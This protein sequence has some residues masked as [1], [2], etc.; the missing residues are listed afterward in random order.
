MNIMPPHNFAPRLIAW[1]RQHGRHNLPWQTTNPYHIWLSEIMLQ[2]TQVA[3]VKPYFTRFIQTLPTLEALAHAS[4]DQVLSLWSG[5]GYYSR[6][7]NLHHSAQTI[8]QQH[9]GQFPQNRHQLEQLKGI[10]RTTAAAI[11]VFAFGKREAILDGNVKR[12]L[13]RHRALN[14]SANDPRT[15]KT[16]WTLAENLLP[17]HPKDLRHYTQGLMDLGST[18]C[19]PRTPQC[20]QCPLQ[21]DC[22]AHQQNRTQQLPLRLKKA[23]KPQQHTTML[24]AIYDN[25]IL[26]QRRPSHGIWQSLWSFPEY[27]DPTQL[28]HH[29]NTPPTLHPL[30]SLKHTFTHYHLHIHPYLWSIPHT[31]PPEIL[32][33]LPTPHTWFNLNQA[34]A[35]GLPKP[36]RTLIQYSAEHN[37]LTA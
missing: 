24:L 6:A 37:W 9:N 28:Q 23:P 12:I 20:P 30:P 25:K 16:L 31:T 15:N 21:N 34:L 18:L 10:G 36:T 19:T 5:L 14:I 4:E 26:L 2:Q 17:H 32:S 29:L 11:A 8:L 22:Q 13:I 35:K 33:Q 7:R 3:S 1:Q 27:T